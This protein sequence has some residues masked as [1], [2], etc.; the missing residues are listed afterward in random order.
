MLAK[1]VYDVNV[2]LYASNLRNPTTRGSTPDTSAAFTVTLK[3]KGP[4]VPIVYACL[5][6]AVIPCVN[7]VP[8]LSVKSLAISRPRVAIFGT[9]IV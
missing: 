5:E 6:A 4:S 9:R 8:S 1:S 2:E 3:W 7:S